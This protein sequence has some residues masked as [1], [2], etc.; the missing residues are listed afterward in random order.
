MSF[1]KAGEFGAKGVKLF[2]RFVLNEVKAA[3]A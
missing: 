3:E 2:Y 1:M